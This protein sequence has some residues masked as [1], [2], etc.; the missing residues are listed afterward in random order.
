M[1]SGNED[2]I[3]RS[4]PRFHQF[5]AHL[6][7]C[8]LRQLKLLTNWSID[9]PAPVWIF[10]ESLP[11]GLLMHHKVTKFAGTLFYHSVDSYVFWIG[12]NAIRCSKRMVYRRSWAIWWF[13]LNSTDILIGCS[14]CLSRKQGHILR[15]GCQSLPLGCGFQKCAV[16]SSSILWE[17][18]IL[19]SAWESTHKEGDI[20]N[21]HPCIRCWFCLRSCP[22]FLQKLAH[23]H[24]Q[25]GK[26]ACIQVI[27]SLP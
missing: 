23:L 3:S 20:L 4:V 7:S 9:W 16:C 27:Q 13:C 17:R 12:R 1:R 11:D 14:E 15:Q 21:A 6:V 19:S 26:S 2:R 22:V 25:L 5:D 8:S 10:G 18:E 24:F